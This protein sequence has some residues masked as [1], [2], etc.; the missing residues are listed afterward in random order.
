MNPAYAITTEKLK[1]IRHVVLDLDGTVYS[2]SKLFSTTIPFLRQ[3]AAA[4]IG[5][6]FLTNNSSVSTAD[7]IAKL[8]KMGIDI[9]EEQIRTSTHSVISYLGTQHPGIRKIFVFGTDSFRNELENAGFVITFGEPDAVIAGFNTELEYRQLCKAAY[10]IRRGK[11]WFTSHP[12]L[13]CPT[14][15]PVVLV[16]CGAVT[17]CLRTV[18]GRRPDKVLGK[19]S[20]EMLE[21]II[22]RHGLRRDEILMVGDRLNTDMQLAR[23]AGTAA[24]MIAAAPEDIAGDDTIICAVRDLGELGKLFRPRNQGNYGFTEYSS[25][26]TPGQKTAEPDGSPAGCE[27]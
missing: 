10:W 24:V 6:T 25:E 11:P 9:T 3:L 2:G 7:Y 26:N 22:E 12:D 4:D 16:D 27:M 13:E 18:T 20:R 8:H 21:P 1:S 14:D 15:A 23:N 5:Y 19:P 17:E